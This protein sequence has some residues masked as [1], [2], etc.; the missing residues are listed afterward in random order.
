MKNSL[1]DKTIC[2]DTHTLIS[3][4]YDEDPFEILEGQ[5]FSG[6]ISTGFGA[7]SGTIIG[8]IICPHL[9]IDYLSGGILAS[10]F[11]AIGGLVS[12]PVLYDY[13]PGNVSYYTKSKLNTFKEKN[14]INNEQIKEEIQK[15]VYFKDNKIIGF[16]KFKNNISPPV[17][18]YYF[19]CDYTLKMDIEVSKK[20]KDYNQNIFKNKIDF[21]DG[22]EYFE[23][24]KKLLNI[25]NIKI[26]N[27]IL[28]LV[29]I[30]II[31][32]GIP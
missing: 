22:K 7:I 21:Y 18:G 17:T 31:F 11:G 16:I 29:K 2:L 25:N 27:K 26:I 10:F 13:S 14:N 20:I 23:K 3:N 12:F 6:L 30:L 5:L 9:L 4:Y 28:T 1:L 24:M 15:F 19:K 8:G 32:I